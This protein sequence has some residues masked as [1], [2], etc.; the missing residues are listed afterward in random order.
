LRRLISLLL[1]FPSLCFSQTGAH[2]IGQILVKGNNVSANVA[3]YAN[4]QVCVAG[5]GCKTLANIFGDAALTSPLTQPL[6]AD[7]SGNYDYY[8]A[9]GCVD[10]QISSPGQGLIFTPNVCPFNGTSGG[11]SANITPAP[12]HKKTFF[13]LPGTVSNVGGDTV[14]TTDG[15]GNE[16]SVSQTGIPFSP[17]VSIP[18]PPPN[19]VSYGPQTLTATDY[20]PFSS[21]FQKQSSTAAVALTITQNVNRR[22]S[23]GSAYGP[24]Q[25]NLNMLSGQD[26]TNIVEGNYGLMALNANVFT[27]IQGG[28]MLGITGNC[29]AV[30]DCVTYEATSVARGVS[31]GEDEGAEGWRF[32]LYGMTNSTAGGTLTS[33]AT[34]AQGAIS[35]TFPSV[36]SNINVAF[37][38]KSFLAD[39]TQKWQSPGN[40]ASIGAATD[41]R[42]EYFQGD[43]TAGIT[44]EFGVSTQTTLT[45]AIDSTVYNDGCPT[46]PV[47][48]A[49]VYPTIGIGFQASGTVGDGFQTDYKGVGLPKQNANYNSVGLL[50]G[51]CITVASTAGSGGGPPLAVGD[52]VLI[53]DSDYQ[54]EYT[55]VLTVVDST[56]FT[57]FI[58]QPHPLPVVGSGLP[59]PTVN[60][61]GGV[62]YGIGMDAD[63]APP[64]TNTYGANQQTVTQYLI[65]PIVQSFTGDRVN[66][67]TNVEGSSPNNL[68]TV[69]PNSNTPVTPLVLSAP[70]VTGGVLMNVTSNTNDYRSSIP[71]GESGHPQYLPAPTITTTGC[72]VAPT[73][74]FTV[75]AGTNSY[76]AHVL[77][78]GSGCGSPTFSVSPFLP[79]PFGIYPMTMVYRIEDWSQPTAGTAGDGK[80]TLMPFLTASNAPTGAKFFTAGDTITSPIWWNGVSTSSQY[81]YIGD[82]L[83]MINGRG[84]AINTINFKGVTTGDA[85]DDY[86]NYE[87]TSHYYG[88]FANNYINTVPMDYLAIPPEWSQLDGQYSSAIFMGFPPLTV[89]GGSAYAGGSIISVGCGRGSAASTLVDPPCLHGIDTKY[90]LFN[91]ISSTGGT[92]TNLS[93]FVNNVGSGSMGIVSN[94]ANTVWQ[95]PIIE[96]YNSS[97]ANP[98]ALIAGSPFGGINKGPCQRFD[99]LNSV[100]GAYNS[101]YGRICGV[102]LAGSGSAGSLQFEV[103]TGPTGAATYVTPLII[104]PTSISTSV[105][106]TSTV[107]TGTAPFPVSSTTLNT[108]FNAALLG[109]VAL[110]GVCQTSGAGCPAAATGFSGSFTTT[111]VASESVPITGMSASGH[112]A[113]APT[114]SSAAASTGS[115]ISTK[116]TNAVTFNHAAV[117]GMSFD[118]I[119]TAN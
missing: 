16:T 94:N 18:A 81:S 91:S 50:K 4:I 10:E 71:S 111:A 6:T 72:T 44:T 62:G 49:A 19:S 119:C 36:G 80:I 2:R 13:N 22:T 113:F 69:I 85:Y 83:N 46:T 52:T 78:G 9:S 8:V 57:A 59:N 24:A 38:E 73:F 32:F 70:V 55:T 54:I 108:N 67:Y 23:A 51:I 77:N 98:D 15:N 97:N 3:P 20:I 106:V 5:T 68:R 41:T 107:T 96:G 86:H 84:G 21:T 11:G 116:T 14:A 117:A 103:N 58:R 28:G 7:G 82:S 104:N 34:D 42:W 93:L 47:T 53:A 25:F 35:A 56:H 61:G 63:I 87:P 64:G 90:N 76:T 48:P 45:H 29:L 39:V 115:Y 12:Q 17:S 26:N 31:R 27:P 79:T 75:T 101:S 65:Y 100:T 105:P 95:A 1:L 92:G 109:G 110:S 99:F 118:F 66:V 74:F 102:S 33:F 30:G 112:C 37:Y 114:N 60:W 89:T 43:G 40:I 88:S